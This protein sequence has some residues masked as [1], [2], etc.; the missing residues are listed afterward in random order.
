[1]ES[2]RL[3]TLV[4][5]LARPFVAR[6][7]EAMV[8]V[9]GLVSREHVLLIGEPGTGKSALARRLASL[10]DARFFKY[11]LT[12]FTEPSELFGPLDIAGLKEGVYRRITRGKLPEA[13]IA[14]LDEIFNANSAV[15]NSL[16]S[17]LQERIVYDGYSEIR[18]SIWTVI[19]A[20]NTIPEEPELE[21][22]Y[23]RFVLRH[24][25]QPVPA[26][27]WDELIDRAIVIEREGYE[28]PRPIVTLEDIAKAYEEIFKVDLSPVKDKL[29]KLFMIFEEKGMHTTD[30]RKGKAAKIIAAH[31]LIHGRRRADLADL[32]VLRYIVPRDIDDFEKV[33]AILFE[34]VRTR[35][36][37]IQELGEIR[38]S[39][40]AMKPEI[41]KARTYSP[42]LIDYYKMLNQLSNRIKSMVADVDDEEL[43]NMASEL[44]DEIQEL[45]S[46]I[47]LKLSM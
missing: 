44:L 37:I 26:E 16:L 5:E 25:V 42:R 30:R 1:M 10:V 34:E 38:R 41:K 43:I 36:K 35:D 3:M 23:D 19:G 22:L 28:A 29:L 24:L 11:L 32:H 21:A 17:L 12:R 40:E 20:S 31:A 27:Y 46:I 33:K 6:R 8:L 7:E 13:E 4:E 47:S 14:F 45:L 39:L 2:A 15:L 18:T 9:L